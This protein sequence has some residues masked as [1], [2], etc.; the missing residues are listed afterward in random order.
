[1][2][3]RVWLRA[4]T[5]SGDLFAWA[6]KIAPIALPTPGAVCRFTCPTRPLACAKPSAIPTATASCR[7][8]TYRKSSG[9]SFSIGSSVE[10]GLPNTVVM[11][12][13]RSRSNVASR[14]VVTR[15]SLRHSHTMPRVAPP[16]YRERLRTEGLALAACGLVG[17]AV[18]V[19]FVPASRRWPLN[20]LAQLAA[21][22]ALLE[23]F[24][25]RKVRGWMRD[26]EELTPGEEGSGEPTPLWMLPPIMVS[27]AAVFVL[28]PE[29]GLPAS[30][31]AGWDA[32]LR[33]TGGCLLVGLVQGVRYERIVA[34]EEAARGRR[35]TRV[36]VSPLWS[37]TKLGWVHD[38]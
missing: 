34:K 27:L 37:G 14:T 23:G 21:V 36:K 3:E 7:P 38:R 17:S 6:L 9:N 32:A 10:P 31:R 13:A 8:S 24:G 30:D 4:V 11:P 19:G 2:S 26:A 16:S 25:T 22:A 28:L 18:L 33:I 12:R 15:G 5:S 29:T 1:M 35:D 20:T